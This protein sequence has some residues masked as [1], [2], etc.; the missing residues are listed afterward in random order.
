MT[1][2]AFQKSLILQNKNIAHGFFGRADGVSE[3]P[4]S[5]LNTGP[6]SNDSSKNVV[7]NRRRCALALG[8]KE[9]HLLTVYQ[10]HSSNV[11]PVEGPWLLDDKHNPIVPKADG[12]VTRTKGLALGAL[13]ADCMPVLFADFDAGVIGAAHAGWRGALAGVLEETVSKMSDLG[14]KPARIRAVFGPSLRQNNFEVGLELVKAFSLKYA[15]AERFFAPA[16]QTD[17]RLLDLV[18]YGQWRLKS[19]GV[20]M[21]DAIDHCTLA[22]PQNYFSYRASQRAN[23]TDYGRNISAIA[24]IDA[25]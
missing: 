23:Q 24:L 1:L 2:P 11:E 17:K 9:N 16:P 19:A 21:I 4:Y 25:D 13:A 8:V 7:E 20:K 10:V 6:G 12:L 3:G 15:E 5:T 18:G 22:M 14:A